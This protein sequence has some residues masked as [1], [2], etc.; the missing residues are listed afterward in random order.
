MGVGGGG[1]GGCGG[2]GTR[3]GQTLRWGSNGLLAWSEGATNGGGAT[4]AGVAAGLAVGVGERVVAPIWAC[5]PVATQARETDSRSLDV[6]FKR[7]TLT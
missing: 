6:E 1:G 4:A 7:D 3:S 2:G 5:T